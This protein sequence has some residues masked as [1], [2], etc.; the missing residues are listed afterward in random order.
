MRFVENLPAFADD[1]ER[2]AQVCRELVGYVVEG[3]GRHNHVARGPQRGGEG[4]VKAGRP[5]GRWCD[6][7]PV[8]QVGQGSSRGVGG[9]HELHPHG[10]RKGTN[11]RRRELGKE[12]GHE[13]VK[14]VAAHARKHGERDVNRDAVGI[15]PGGELV[16]QR[17]FEGGVRARDDLQ[18][19]LRHARGVDVGCAGRE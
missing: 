3:F 15:L 5:G 17:Q 7:G 18:P 4:L 11:G 6:V 16:G 2:H 8:R 19:G 14:A 12:R 10:L 13:P 1:P 9:G